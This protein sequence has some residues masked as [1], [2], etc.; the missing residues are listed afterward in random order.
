MADHADFNVVRDR[1]G[2]NPRVKL[3]AV[4]GRQCIAFV[5]PILTVVSDDE[6]SEEYTTAMTRFAN[7]LAEKYPA[8]GG[9]MVVLQAS[10]PPPNAEA[11]KRI[12]RIYR[13][14]ERGC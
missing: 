2:A 6:P 3:L 8:K 4:L 13:S 14:F 12:D 1:L 5:G 10:A 9:W 11:R 7:E